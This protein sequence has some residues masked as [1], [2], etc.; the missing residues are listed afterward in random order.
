MPVPDIDLFIK[1]FARIETDPKS[2]NQEKWRTNTQCGTSMCFAG[3]AADISGGRWTNDFGW[4]QSHLYATFE[5]IEQGIA[6]EEFVNERI[7][8]IIFVS[9]RARRI[10]GITE[11]EASY[12]F[13]STNSLSTLY[14]DASKILGIP[15]SA[16]KTLVQNYITDNRM[17]NAK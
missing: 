6:I 3:H 15:V 5:E 4:T 11:Y 2:W 16:L 7:E 1:V 12:L 10:L 9:E 17:T 8:H 13:E 14:K